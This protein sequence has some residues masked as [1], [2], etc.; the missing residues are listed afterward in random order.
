MERDGAVVP[1]E[2]KSSKG[3]TV[4]LNTFMAQYEPRVAYKL[5]D[6][7]SGRNGAK[8]TLPQFMGM[9]L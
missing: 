1:V 9:F 5:V 7:N 3:A 6:G 2:V 8:V 4:S